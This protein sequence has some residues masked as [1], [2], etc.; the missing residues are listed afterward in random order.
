M[1]LAQSGCAE[2]RIVGQEK[3]RIKVHEWP[4]LSDE[5]SV[6]ESGVFTLPIVGTLEAAGRTAGEIAQEISTRLQE[7]AQLK[8][9]PFASVEV[10]HFPP[11][12]ILGDVQRP[13]EYHYRPGLTVVAALSMAGGAYRIPE[14][15]LLRDAITGRGSLANLE[16]QRRELLVRQARLTAELSGSDRLELDPVTQGSAGALV[17]AAIEQ[18]RSIMQGIRRSLNNQVV[19][20]QKENDIRREEIR[21]LKARMDSSIKQLKS[22]QKE[23]AVLSTLSERGLTLA[24]RQASLDRLAAQIEGDQ[25]AIDTLIA[26]AQAVI[27]Q[28]EAASAKLADERSREAS[29]ELRLV[30]A[31]LEQIH[32][33]LTGQRT[34]LSVAGALGVEEGAQRGWGLTYRMAR[35]SSDGVRETIV[36]DNDSIQPGDVIKVERNLFGQAEIPGRNEEKSTDR[37]L[38]STG[39]ERGSN[40]LR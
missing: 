7:R 27:I 28:N 34:L 26:Q 25:R 14:S 13:G 3:V 18:E 38:K 8:E 19:A 11:F 4:A 16:S 2:Y 36:R 15:S 5:L 39:P 21:F 30:T 32:A 29:H 20:L 40:S 24:P 37:V 12:Y 17:A 1:C 10:S 22:V 23:I 31:Q 33:Q 9:P 35:I 6:G